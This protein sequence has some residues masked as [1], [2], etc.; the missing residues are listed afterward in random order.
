MDIN[1][2]MAQLTEFFSHGIG[3]IIGDVL[4]VLYH[5]LY[6]ANAEAPR[7]PEVAD[8]ARAAVETTPEA[9]TA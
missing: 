1:T 7:V 4:R 2:L 9:T 5:F 6:P 3:R 8:A